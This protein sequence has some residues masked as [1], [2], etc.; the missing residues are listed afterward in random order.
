MSNKISRNAPCPCGS[1]K[2]Y[3]QCHG[4]LDSP[5]QPAEKSPYLKT[6]QIEKLLEHIRQ[7][8]GWR[9]RHGAGKLIVHS[10]FNGKKIIAVGNEL[11]WMPEERCKF[12]PDF[13]GR[14]LM[15]VL[16]PEWYAAQRLLPQDEQHQIAKLYVSMCRFQQAVSRDADGTYRIEPSG[17]MLVWNRLA[18]DMYLIRHNAKLQRDIIDRLRHKDQFQ[19]ARYELCVAAA[20][21]VAGFE[22][23]YAENDSEPGKKVEFVAVHKK[24]GLELSVEAKSRRRNGVLD[25]VDS[26][27][28]PG[29][30]GIANLLGE[31]LAKN[32]SRAY[33]I[34]IDVNLPVPNE[35]IVG[36]EW[37]RE[38]RQ[39]IDHA[40]GRWGGNTFPASATICTNDPSH[41]YM[42]T[43]APQGNGVDGFGFWAFGKCHATALN[44]LEGEIL[45]GILIALSQRSKIPN[46]FPDQRLVQR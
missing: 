38:V 33:V 17:A 27:A 30:V 39:T 44:P 22:I 40:E 23:N 20:F 19:G 3:K 6:P 28:K 42:D 24:T 31:A 34:C 37:Y 15:T 8:I 46:E 45:E 11:H 41:Y 10:N 12:F 7:N 18:Y 5:S 29:G 25:Y 1:G 16:T 14:H 21:I 43:V 36:G 13:L 4:S 9:D 35:S 32:P 2:K 26:N